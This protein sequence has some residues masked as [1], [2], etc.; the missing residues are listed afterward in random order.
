MCVW[1]RLNTPPHTRS[2]GNRPLAHDIQLR[3]SRESTDIRR[4]DELEGKRTLKSVNSKA[5]RHHNANANTARARHFIYESFK[6]ILWVAPI[7]TRL[8][9]WV[10]GQRVSKVLCLHDVAWCG[11]G[12]VR[13]LWGVTGG[14]WGGRGCGGEG[15]S[16]AL[17]LSGRTASVEGWACAR[18]QSYRDSFRGGIP[19][20]LVMHD[21]W[22]RLTSPHDHDQWGRLTSPH[23]HDQW[24]WL[25]SPHDHDQWA[26][27]DPHDH[28]HGGRLTSPHDHDQRGRSTSPP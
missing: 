23:D 12:G 3:G 6:C 13:E 4:R 15:G 7:E 8:A 2:P 5:N 28:D 18:V 10:G 17:M 24:G 16:G 20:L 26:Q 9:G 1:L 25:T 21:Q 14:R 22:G 27:G 11:D 19:P